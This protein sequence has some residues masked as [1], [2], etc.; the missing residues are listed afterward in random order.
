MDYGDALLK[1]YNFFDE[2]K[3]FEL[4]QK[5]PAEVL[6]RG[7]EPNQQL[8]IKQYDLPRSA[9]LNPFFPMTVAERLANIENL[10]KDKDYKPSRQRQMSYEQMSPYA[11]DFLSGYRPDQLLGPKK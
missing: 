6:A 2:N 10:I 9:P 4:Y 8:T 1:T 11:F 7:A 5:S 3:P